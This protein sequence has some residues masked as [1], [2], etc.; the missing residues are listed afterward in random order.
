[1]VAN[2]IIE[3]DVFLGIFSAFAATA[4]SIITGYFNRDRKNEQLS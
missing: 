1:M 4:G 2:K 3:V